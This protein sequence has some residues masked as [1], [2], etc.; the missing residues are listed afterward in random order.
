VSTYV[1]VFDEDHSELKLEG[2]LFDR[3][4]LASMVMEAVLEY[5]AFDADEGAKASIQDQKI[6]ESWVFVARVRLPWT[7][8]P[9][10]EKIFDV[11]WQTLL[12]GVDPSPYN[13]M[14]IIFLKWDRTV[15]WF[16]VI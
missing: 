6:L 16:R 9:T 15:I 7:K 11:Y 13:V 14:R 3:I 5:I 4:I 2:Y 8:Y 12:A 1:P 10:G